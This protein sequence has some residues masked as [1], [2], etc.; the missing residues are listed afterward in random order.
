MATPNPQDLIAHTSTGLSVTLFGI[1][2]AITD[3]LQVVAL[4][5]A[6]VVSIASYR[7]STARRK[8]IEAKKDKK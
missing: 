2:F 8:Y 3:V 7:L 4:I 6:I 5:G 1:S